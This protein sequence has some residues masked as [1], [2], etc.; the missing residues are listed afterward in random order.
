M[1]IETMQVFCHHQDY[2][3]PWWARRLQG[4][5]DFSILLALASLLFG[6]RLVAEKYVDQ[7]NFDR[8][9]IRQVM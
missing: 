3:L 2:V 6:R 8:G 1:R 9:R 4:I 7:L 5:G